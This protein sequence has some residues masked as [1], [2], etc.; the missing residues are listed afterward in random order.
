MNGDVVYYERETFWTG[1]IPN[2]T[3]IHNAQRI[4]AIGI[5]SCCLGFTPGYWLA[6]IVQKFKDKKDIKSERVILPKE[7]KLIKSVDRLQ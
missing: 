7:N 4:A 1:L 6:H 2:K 3:E 5:I